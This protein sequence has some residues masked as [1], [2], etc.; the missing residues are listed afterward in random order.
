MILDDQEERD[1]TE[2]NQTLY[3]L[4]ISWESEEGE[5]FTSKEESQAHKELEE[6]IKYLKE[7]PGNCTKSR[8][9]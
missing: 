4:G 5:V 2:T 7:D 3:I 8:E 9:R 1:H 6:I